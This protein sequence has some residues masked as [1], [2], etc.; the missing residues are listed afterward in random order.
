GRLRRAASGAAGAPGATA[1]RDSRLN[2]LSE[3]ARARFDALKAWRREVAEQ[4]ELPAYIV[5]SDATLIA[6]AAAGPRNE[7]ELAAISGV[8]EK[9]LAAYGEEI[10]R[11]CRA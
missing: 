6:I 2:A 5:F 8:G 4:H 9:K 11:I 10:L 7:D 3:L 1:S